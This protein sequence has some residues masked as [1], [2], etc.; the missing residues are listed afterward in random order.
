MEKSLTAEEVKAIELDLLLKFH[1]LCKKQG[2]RYSLGGG[3]LLG[4]I[5]HKGFIPWDDDIDVMMPRPD[6]EAFLEYCKNNEVDFGIQT[7]DND[8]Q[9]V[10]MSSKL[11]DKT[12]RLEFD[13]MSQTEVQVGVHMDVFVTDGLGNTYEEAVKNFRKSSFLRELLVAA[14][15]DKFFRSK[16]RSIIYEPIRF[17]FYVMSRFVNKQKLFEKIQN[18]YKHNDYD[19][20]KYVAA[21]GGAYREKEIL[22]KEG[23]FD[24]YVEVDFE[25]HKVMAIKGYDKYLTSLYGDYMT[26]PPADKQKSHHRF[27]AYK[28]S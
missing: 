28:E 11:F 9:F 17:A 2:F 19:N 16:T 24:E 15:W 25:N 10:D 12:T 26:P 23:I 14:Q 4:A 3:T 27:T 1:D 18:K 21:V 20:L 5:R 6:Y 7:Y 22:P 8:K 13:S